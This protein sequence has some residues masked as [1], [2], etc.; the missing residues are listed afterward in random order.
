MGRI[1]RPGFRRPAPL[2]LIA[3]SAWQVPIS[4]RPSACDDDQVILFTKSV[5][6]SGAFHAAGYRAVFLSQSYDGFASVRE[7]P[8]TQLTGESL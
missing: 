1:F 5:I 8:P 2:A 4:L 6:I 7:S 3:H